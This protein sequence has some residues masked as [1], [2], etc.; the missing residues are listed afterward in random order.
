MNVIQKLELKTG[1]HKNSVN[2]LILFGD[3]L[4]VSCSDDSRIIVWKIDE[5]KTTVIP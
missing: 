2:S 5:P 1:G 3:K 4:L